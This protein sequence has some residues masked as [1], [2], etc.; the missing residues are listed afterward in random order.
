MFVPQQTL[1]LFHHCRMKTEQSCFYYYDKSIGFIF[2][3]ELGVITKLLR[4]EKIKYTINT[5]AVYQ[6]ALYGFLLE[7]N[8]YAKEVKK[9]NYSSII[10]FD[11]ASMEL[12]IEKHQKY[13]NKKIDLSYSDALFQINEL[14][15]KSITSNWNK[16][17]EYTL[18]LI[19]ISEPTRP[20]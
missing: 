6:M 16:D 5:D 17:K 20:Y 12:N 4:K 18:S 2:S 3:S 13:S 15:E 11:T 10:T 1:D 9:L 14:M 8:T 7:D 19:H